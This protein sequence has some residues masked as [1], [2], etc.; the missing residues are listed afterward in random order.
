MRCAVV[1]LLAAL[2][3][4]PLYADDARRLTAR[5][6]AASS[7]THFIGVAFVGRFLTGPY[8]LQLTCGTSSPARCLTAAN[9]RPNMTVSASL[10]SSDSVCSASGSYYMKKYEVPLLSGEAISIGVSASFAPYIELQRPNGDGIGKWVEGGDDVVP[11]ES[12]GIEKWVMCYDCRVKWTPPRG[13]NDAN[14]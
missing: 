13:T 8:I 11:V 4:V 1:V 2:C 7:G 6:E 10:T 5:V 9:L 3:V 14:L 12:E